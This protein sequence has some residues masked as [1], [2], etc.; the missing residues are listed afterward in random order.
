M[1]KE[2]YIS[3]DKDIND[4]KN[5]PREYIWKESMMELRSERLR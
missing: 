2:Q 3:M 4:S 1:T 5:L